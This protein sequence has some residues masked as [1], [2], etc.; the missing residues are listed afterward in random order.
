[1][2]SHKSDRRNSRRHPLKTAARLRVWKSGFSER[3][4]ETENVSAQ[5]ALLASEVPFSV[6]SLV[7]I[8]L[9]MPQEITGE[10]C[11]DWR[12]S[13]RVVRIQPLDRNRGKVGLGVEFDYY[14]I[15][16]SK[17]GSNR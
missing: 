4:A 12:C 13:G 10:P 15:L 16:R 11:A 17:A 7:E 8:L 9:T 14:E 2:N 1:M 3:P 5:G 6:G